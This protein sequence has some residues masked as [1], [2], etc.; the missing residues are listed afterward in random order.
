MLEDEPP[1][2]EGEIVVS[3][4]TAAA[5]SRRSRL[6]GRRRAAAVRGPR[7]A[8]PGR[9]STTSRRPTTPTMRAAE[10]AVLD[11]LGVNARRPTRGGRRTRRRRGRGGGRCVTP[12]VAVVDQLAAPGRRRRSSASAYR[13]LREFS[14][15]DLEEICRRRGKPDRFGEILQH[16][17]DVALGVEMLSAFTGVARR[18][19]RRG[20][21]RRF[22]WDYSLHESLGELLLTSLLLG[23]GPGHAFAPGRRGPA[24]GCSPRGFC[25]TPGRC[26]GLLA[27]VHAAAGLGR[28]G[29]STRCCTASSAATPQEVDEQAIEEEIRTIVSE[30]HREGLLED[31]A[32]EMIEGVIDLGDAYVSQIMTPRTDMH[33]I[34][35]DAPWDEMLADVIES[36]HT[37]IPVLR[38]DPRRHRR[39]PVQQ[40]PAARAGHRRSRARARRCASWCASRCSCPRR[41]RSTTCCRCSSSCARTSPWCS[42]NTAAS[43]AW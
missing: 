4:D 13:A 21:G 20:L 1:Q 7:R 35:V 16:H 6:V 15:H 40:G 2:L 31:E 29:C 39:H 9:L 18:D 12:D 28:P 24:P 33:M 17:D 8:A 26:G 38:Q 25:T 3:V 32:R 11:R 36:G 34:Q 5:R 43:R 14:R 19:R 41:R 10:A 23:S 37:R 27:G 30:G 42:T 22:D